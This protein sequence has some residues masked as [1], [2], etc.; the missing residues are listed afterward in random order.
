MALVRKAI[1]MYESKS[2]FGTA[3]FSTGE[4]TPAASSLLLVTVL[5]IGNNTT[6]DIGTPT[7]E[8]GGLSYTSVT[9]AFGSASWSTK[10]ITFRAQV[11]SEPKAMK[12]T[13]DDDNNQNIDAYTVSVIQYTGHDTTTPIAGIVTSGSTNIGDG[14]ETQTLSAAPVEADDSINV[15]GVDASAGPPKPVYEAGWTGIHEG[16]LSGEGGLAIAGRSAST[17]TTVKVKDV[18]NPGTGSFAKGMMYSF[19]V[20]AAGGDVT[21]SVPAASASAG[22]AAPTPLISVP[23]AS[24]TATAAGASP[25]PSASIAPP[26]AAAVASAAGP[27]ASLSV[28]AV[29]AGAIAGAAPPTPQASVAVPPG[30]AVAAVPSPAIAI[31]ISVPPGQA[32]ASVTPPTPAVFIATPPAPAT[33]SA[34]APVVVVEEALPGG[35]PPV[36]LPTTCAVAD[37]S[38]RV[39]QLIRT[40]TT[41]VLA[42]SRSAASV[43]EQEAAIGAIATESTDAALTA[44]ES[45]VAIVDQRGEVLING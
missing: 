37:P 22:A 36:E 8:G 27:A 38:A 7:I 35:A 5:A 42:V 20:K 45:R 21:I 25:T 19:I 6:G 32:E 39:D 33:A 14:E 3:A 30:Q 31:D 17:S 44:R 24:A 2:A 16:K 18:S 1:G 23:A 15:I 9:S 13:V 4:F 28:P 40:T 34:P 12:V 43:E 26:P 10:T 41:G 29:A 11:G